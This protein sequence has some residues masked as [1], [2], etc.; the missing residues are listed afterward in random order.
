M[1]TMFVRHSVADYSAWKQVYDTEGRQAQQANG[2]LEESVY[3]DADDPN[4]VIVTHKFEDIDAARRFANLDGLKEAMQ[5]AG[6]KGSP[7][8]WF[9]EEV[10]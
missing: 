4:F 7:T 6:V 5:H 3:R 2:V 9:G 10:E 1:T 8:F